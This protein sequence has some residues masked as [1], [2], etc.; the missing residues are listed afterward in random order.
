LIAIY[1]VLGLSILSILIVS[2]CFYRRS[3]AHIDGQD[4]KVKESAFTKALDA[5]YE[6]A[7]RETSRSEMAKGKKFFSGEPEE[8][9]KL[10]K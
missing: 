6:A 10:I 1:T 2:V 3:R 7:M 8:K 5:D 9:N 4:S